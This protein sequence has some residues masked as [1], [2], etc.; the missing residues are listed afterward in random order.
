MTYGKIEIR[1]SNEFSRSDHLSE[2]D[3]I[4][5]KQTDAL[6]LSDNNVKIMNNARLEIFLVFLFLFCG[7]NLEKNRK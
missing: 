4:T 6:F 5:E 1:I 2:K 3:L 7:F